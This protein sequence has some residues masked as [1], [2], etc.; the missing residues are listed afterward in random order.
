M[1]IKDYWVYQKRDTPKPW[2][3]YVVK[4]YDKRVGSRATCLDVTYYHENI[5]NNLQATSELCIHYDT[6]DEYVSH[7]A[8][9]L[10]EYAYVTL[11]DEKQI[12]RE[13]SPI[14]EG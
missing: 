9:K 10:A 11:A 14:L 2:A 7:I 3:L 8:E 6:L 12:E 1:A 5:P 4:E 13:L